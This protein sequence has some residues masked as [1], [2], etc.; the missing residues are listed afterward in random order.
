MDSPPVLWRAAGDNLLQLRP[1]PPESQQP[2]P[3]LQLQLRAVL[4]DV[5]E[6]SRVL[7]LV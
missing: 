1:V 5:P 4:A 6:V 3:Q 2:R 7:K